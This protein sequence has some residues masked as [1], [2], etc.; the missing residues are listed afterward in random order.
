[1]AKHS[2]GIVTS[3]S[4]REECE[5]RKSRVRV[6]T[7]YPDIGEISG[8]SAATLGSQ[9]NKVQENVNGGKNEKTIYVR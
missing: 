1:M 4:G 2:W 9:M 5:C 8:T 3:L 7:K 6:H